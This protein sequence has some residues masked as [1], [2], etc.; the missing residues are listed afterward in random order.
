LPREDARFMDEVQEHVPLTPAGEAMRHGLWGGR[1]DDE[2]EAALGELFFEGP[3]AAERLWRFGSLIVL[4][5]AIAAF[6]LLA[7]SAGVVIGAMLVAPLMTPIQALGAALVHGSSRRILSSALVI[8]GGFL[9]AV[10]TGYLVSMIGGGNVTVEALPGEILART[11]PGLLDLGIAVAAGA[12]GGYVIARPAA[13]S[14]LPGVGIAVALVPPLATVG[15]C[16]ELGQHDLAEG[17][18]LLFATNLA[19]IVL[20]GAVMIFAAGYRPRR[21]A[22]T[23]TV[24]RLGF[25]TAVL[26]VIA[27]SVPLAIHTRGAV[28]DSRAGRIVDDAIP[29]WDP[30]V[31]VVSL[32]VDDHD[33][34]VSVD[35]V[36]TSPSTPVSVW[37]LAQLLRERLD[38]PVTVQLRVQL[39]TVD[40]AIAT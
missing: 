25:L 30:L 32:L 22:R 8:L 16:I 2:F 23:G 11:A 14:A 7:D 36:V 17:A 38:K 35:L 33:G 3:A 28:E 10:V 24:A 34:T 20:S 29:E 18:L 15:I 5:A 26:L 40:R 37:E 21:S 13:S 12:A 31:R 39:E 9:G 19:A 6:G 4:S 27:V 1:P